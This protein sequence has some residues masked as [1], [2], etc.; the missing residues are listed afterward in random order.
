MPWV[1]F[2]KCRCHRFLNTGFCEDT[3]Q[4]NDGEVFGNQKHCINGSFWFQDRADLQVYLGETIEEIIL[5]GEI[6]VGDT[7]TVDMDFSRVQVHFFWNDKFLHSFCLKKV[8][9]A[10]I[11][12]K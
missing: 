6:V 8:E 5:E 2:G 10:L 12:G 4:V 3:F 7:V 1:S 9:D 11:G